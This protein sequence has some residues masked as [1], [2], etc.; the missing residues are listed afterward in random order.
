[1]G[2][3][4]KTAI[5]KRIETLLGG[6]FLKFDTLPQNLN[7]KIAKPLFLSILS[8]FLLGLMTP[9][10]FS[11]ICQELYYEVK[12]PQWYD[13]FDPELSHNLSMAVNVA[14]YKYKGEEFYNSLIFGLKNYYNK[15]KKLL[16]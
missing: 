13:S 10:E 2:K 1:L 3:G 8:D 14:W 5:K 4:P 6:Y 7:Y 16:N 15:N 12:N 9:E 11:L